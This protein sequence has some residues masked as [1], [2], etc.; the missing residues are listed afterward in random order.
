MR[1]CN[2]VCNRD[3]VKL[4]KKPIYTHQDYCREC[5][6]YYHKRKFHTCPCCKCMVRMSGVKSDWKRK[7]L[8]STQS[9]VEHGKLPIP[10]LYSCGFPKGI[11]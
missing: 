7:H 3:K 5:E 6:V 8:N 2:G 10:I 9:I 11:L 1:Q 4:I